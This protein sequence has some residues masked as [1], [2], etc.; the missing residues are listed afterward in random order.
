MLKRWD[1]NREAMMGFGDEIPKQVW[2]AAQR[3]PSGAAVLAK[4]SGSEALPDGES[5]ARFDTAS[6][7]NPQY[8]NST[9][10]NRRLVC[11]LHREPLGSPQ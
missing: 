6:R 1:S 7:L 10:I 4:Q 8:T 3:S 2:A 5:V 11:G 9:C